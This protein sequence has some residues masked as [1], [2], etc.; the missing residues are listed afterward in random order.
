MNS[1]IN[2]AIRHQSAAPVPPCTSQE[3]ACP[4]CGEPDKLSTTFGPYATAGTRA[5]RCSRCECKI[6]IRTTVTLEVVR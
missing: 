3:I 4:H 1:A 6:I 2:P 5:L